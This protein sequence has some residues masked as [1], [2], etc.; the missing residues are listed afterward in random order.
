MSQGYAGE[1]NARAREGIRDIK[2]LMALDLAHDRMASKG[3]RLAE[4][5]DEVVDG[6][7]HS[8][9][10]SFFEEEYEEGMMPGE[11]RYRDQ[12]MSFFE[13]F[14]VE[15]YEGE[16]I[17]ELGSPEYWDMANE[18]AEAARR[19]AGQSSEEIYGREYGFEE[20][21]PGR[22]N[23]FI[24]FIGTDEGRE[25]LDRAYHE[26][27]EQF[28]QVDERFDRMVDSLE[29]AI[30]GGEEPSGGPGT[31]PAGGPGG[32]PGGEP[33]E[34]GPGGTGGGPGTETREGGPTD[35]GEV[36]EDADI[37]VSVYL[38]DIEGG[39][40]DHGEP[41]YPE[42]SVGI[43]GSEDELRQA[44]TEGQGLGIYLADGMGRLEG[45]DVPEEI[46]RAVRNAGGGANPLQAF[47][48]ELDDVPGYD[49]SLQPVMQT[50][51]RQTGIRITDEGTVRPETSEE[52]HIAYELNVSLPESFSITEEG[53]Y[54]IRAAFLEETGD[55][56]SGHRVYDSAVSK[57]Q[58]F[59][60]PGAG[61]PEYDVDMS[62]VPREREM[63]GNSES[64]PGLME[65]FKSQVM[66]ED[67]RSEYAVQLQ[68]EDDEELLRYLKDMDEIQVR[69]APG[70]S[71]NEEGD[72]MV[73][74]SDF[75]E[76]DTIRSPDL[77]GIDDP[78]RAREYLEDL[79]GVSVH[80]NAVRFEDTYELG[81]RGE[82]L[83]A[84]ISNAFS[85]RGMPS[86]Y[87]EAEAVALENKAAE[88]YF[89]EVEGEHFLNFLSDDVG[90][91]L[92]RL[93]TTD[94]LAGRSPGYYT[95]EEHGDSMYERFRG[96]GKEEQGIVTRVRKGDKINDA[97]TAALGVEGLK[98][99]SAG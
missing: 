31:G 11:S 68:A 78:D 58:S 27:R 81:E 83:L 23:E 34:G 95:V 79:D 39:V 29:G 55:G 10:R 43:Q 20:V 90:G 63:P 46:E 73:S 96:A 80:G 6:D 41:V 52:G 35:T 64:V 7:E 14:M 2:K 18:I 92:H 50:S 99:I 5:Y 33:G 25:E 13:A 69:A 12:A 42:Y 60:V 62:I 28:L 26:A 48:S 98:R 70:V 87:F 57:P 44:L 97:V 51:E 32:E 75:L 89:E 59:E 94:L 45:F 47:M 3:S 82:G 56:I 24:W 88:A 54:S 36:A 86:V 8:D 71:Q 49:A 1:A 16:D 91:F 21:D 77:E 84:N 72:V 74:R 85:D 22:V 4:V 15:E 67:K 76:E 65:A 40:G 61:E 30:V 66:G 53:D 9:I 37:D 17:P 93:D 38:E 19:Y